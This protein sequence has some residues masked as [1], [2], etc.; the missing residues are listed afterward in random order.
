MQLVS[1]CIALSARVMK[2]YSRTTL[3]YTFVFLSFFGGD[4]TS[5][6]SL[7]VGLRLFFSSFAPGIVVFVI[8]GS[9]CVTALKFLMS[10]ISVS[11]VDI[12]G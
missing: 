5:S 4:A 9:S 10:V 11:F 6:P 8:A 12:P 2:L 3:N 7:L 1:F